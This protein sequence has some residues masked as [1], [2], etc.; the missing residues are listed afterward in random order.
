LPFARYG[1]NGVGGASA[2]HF[3]V[4]DCGIVLIASSMGS[5]VISDVTVDGAATPFQIV[6]SFGIVLENVRWAG[7]GSYGKIAGIGVNFQGSSMDPKLRGCCTHGFPPRSVFVFFLLWLYWVCHMFL[8]LLILIFLKRA[9][10]VAFFGIDEERRSYFFF[11]FFFFFF[12]LFG[13]FFLNSQL[14]TH[15][16]TQPTTQPTNQPTKQLP[17][18]DGDDADDAQC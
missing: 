8:L 15:V 16:Y 3:D 18:A 1:R 17:P 14:T 5:L 13:S 4:R 11:F 7:G 2:S 9:S 6:N 12:F 10:A